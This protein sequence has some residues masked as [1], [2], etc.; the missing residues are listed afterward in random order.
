[1]KYKL[2]AIDVDGTL[3]GPDGVVTDDVTGAV[4]AARRAG[5]AVC[6]ATG[7]SYV[8]TLPIWRQLHLAAPFEPIV[9]IGGA[10]VS[11]PDT[12]RSLCQR[13]MPRDL[14]CQFDEALAAAG[15]CAMAIVDAWRYGLDYYLTDG[16]DRDQADRRWFSQMNVKV[17]RVGRLAD[18]ADLLEPLRISTVV[19]P[20]EGRRLAA[21]LAERFNGLLNIHSIFAPNYG[22][23]IVEAFAAGTDKF[24]A[25]RYIAQGG[26]IP[27]SQ[28]AAV[29]DDVNDLT[30]IRGAGLGAAMPNSPA[31]VAAAARHLADRGLA[32]FIRDLLA[33]RFD[34]DR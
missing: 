9:L 2:L 29:G 25:V 21:A 11:E 19:E 5:L 32:A 31:E 33:G 34:G 16:A 4:A 28:I 23:T 12:G 27:P 18:E 20:D 1:M 13:A 15:H 26:L 8:E 24:A 14:A 7:R 6:L 22:V 3:V 17:R 10:L 30:M